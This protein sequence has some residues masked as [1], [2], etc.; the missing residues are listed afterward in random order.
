MGVDSL[1]VVE[2][3]P[4][5]FALERQRALDPVLQLRDGEVRQRGEAERIDG[6]RRTEVGEVCG[7]RSQEADP[8]FGLRQ[9][10]ERQQTNTYTISAL[11]LD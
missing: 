10:R 1:L 7:Q 6:T 5:E 9:R 4:V 11:S 2:E 8:R 3:H